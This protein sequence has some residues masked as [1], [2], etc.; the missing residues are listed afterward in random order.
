MGQQQ[1]ASQ[2]SVPVSRWQPSSLKCFVVCFWGCCFCWLGDLYRQL[3][4]V[5]TSLSANADP[6][7]LVS[8]FVPLRIP[9]VPRMGHVPACS[10]LGSLCSARQCQMC[11]WVLWTLELPQGPQRHSGAM[12]KSSFRWRVYQR[13]IQWGHLPFSLQGGLIQRLLP[14]ERD[15]IQSEITDN[16]QDPCPRKSP[17]IVTNVWSAAGSAVP[18]ALP[19]QGCQGLVAIT[20]AGAFNCF[21]TGTREQNWLKQPKWYQLFPAAWFVYIDYRP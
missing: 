20:P 2:L 3:F 11:C 21:L 4:L 7:S 13:G 6:C 12:Q 18:A 19:A 16:W 1:V 14:A 15:I 17:I 8:G 5:V 9:S 10:G